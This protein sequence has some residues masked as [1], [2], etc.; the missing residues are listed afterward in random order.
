[1]DYRIL[2]KR[3]NELFDKIMS[4]QADLSKDKIN[5]ILRRLFEHS[6]EDGLILA[7]KLRLTP[8]D[9]VFVLSEK[10]NFFMKHRDFCEKLSKKISQKHKDIHDKD[11]SDILVHDFNQRK[12]KLKNNA[13]NFELYRTNAQKG[14]SATLIAQMDDIYKNYLALKKIKVEDPKDNRSTGD[15][16]F[17]DFANKVSSM[18]KY[19]QSSLINTIYDEFISNASTDKTE[20]I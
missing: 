11:L 18:G 17:D 6:I 9:Y 19:F 12:K 4:A 3:K 1:M 2:E 16:L 7:E 8:M 14:P 20:S 5:N 15:K 13:G 10:I